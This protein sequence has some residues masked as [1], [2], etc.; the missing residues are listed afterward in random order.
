M[1]K[2]SPVK[3]AIFLA[4]LIVVFGGVGLA[5][6]GLYVNVHE[7]DTA[8]MVSIVARML[9]G[10][11][12]HL[13]FST[14]IGIVAFLPVVWTAKA[15]FGIGQAFIAAQVVVA[16]LLAPMIW[17]V[18]VSRLTGVSSWLFA[19]LTMSMLMALVHGEASTSISV[20]MYYNRWAWGMAFVAVLL[21][22][23]APQKGREAPVRDG[24]YLGLMFA[25]MAMSKPTYFVAFFPVVTIALLSRGAVRDF[26]VM[27]ATGA[28]VA[29][30]IALVYGIDIYFAYIADLLSVVTSEARAAPS[31]SLLEVLNA[32]RFLVVT[33]T[34]VAA[35]IVLRQSAQGRAG[36]LLFLLLPAFVFV[37]YQNFGNDPK[38][39]MLL[40]FF[41]LA[42]RPE[43][44][45][46]VMFNWEARSAVTALG[47]VAFALILPSI[48]N[49]ITSPFRHLATDESD[50]AVHIS[51][52]PKTQD[53][54]VTDMRSSVAMVRVALAD[55]VPALRA[56]EAEGKGPEPI[57]FLDQTVPQCN[58]VAGEAAMYRYMSD[59]LKDD[60][61]NYPPETQF[62]VVDVVDMLWMFGGFTPLKGAAPWHYSGAPGVENADAIV[63]PL[64]PLAT[65][66]TKIALEA[67][68]VAGL[69]LQRPIKD[70]LFWVFPIVKEG[71]E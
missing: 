7:G 53:I 45:R 34:G 63:V 32:P 12:P 58:L 31:A 35:V 8:H 18:G 49:M 54:Y 50:Y 59:H 15:G 62:F 67:L 10:Q 29:V 68:E 51:G 24:I 56:F 30:V 14:P 46:R 69:K 17:R 40:G 38:W 26:V 52:H 71:A 21:S 65:D 1:S 22:V 44:G 6:G 48:Q 19:L 41:L 13:D 61:F 60:P 37:T 36:L 55:D 23:L 11:V 2:V 66:V 57:T 47:A 70:E 64:C 5:K 25:A 16:A 33:L 28:V 39:L 3:Y 9:A 27:M 42:H 43:T 20:S 4:A